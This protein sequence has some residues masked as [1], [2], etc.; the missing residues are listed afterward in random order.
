MSSAASS[1]SIKTAAMIVPG[2]AGDLE[3]LLDEPSAEALGHQGKIQNVA[4]VCHPHPLYG[5]TMTN[6]VVHILARTCNDL[7]APSVRFNFR[8]VGKSAGAHDDGRGET[9]DTLAMIRWAKGRW[10]AADIW[11][12]GFSFGAAMALR[13]SLHVGS[14]LGRLITVAPAL[15]WLIQVKSHVPDCPWLIVQGD[16]DE[17]VDAQA[18]QTWAA[19]LSRPPRVQILRG[20]EH[21]FHGRLNDLREVVNEWLTKTVV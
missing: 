6:K 17:L 12:A 10:P 16:Q 9:E 7:G 11:L 3:V 1:T 20:A 15:R 4:V 19:S 2:P 8:G 18:V 14:D 5:G 13:A 21:F